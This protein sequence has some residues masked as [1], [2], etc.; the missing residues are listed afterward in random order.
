MFM[1]ALWWPLRGSRTGGEGGSRGSG[2]EGTAL[3]LAG[4]MG[5]DPVEAEEG[6]ASGKW[7]AGRRRPRQAAGHLDVMPPASSRCRSPA[8]RP[9]PPTCSPNARFSGRGPLLPL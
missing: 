2:A 3:V 7:A 9:S 4:V 1:G 8:L 6:A 5:A